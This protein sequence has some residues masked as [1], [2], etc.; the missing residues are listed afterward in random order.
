VAG[1]AST[2]GPKSAPTAAFKERGVTLGTGEQ[3]VASARGS[4][5]AADYPLWPAV[6]PVALVRRE[7]VEPITS[8]ASAASTGAADPQR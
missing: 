4:E 6:A 5:V 7:M 8:S 2:Q 3:V 1:A